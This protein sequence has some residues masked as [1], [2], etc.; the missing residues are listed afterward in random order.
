LV[1]FSNFHQ[2]LGEEADHE[3]AARAIFGLP[4]RG[5]V[6]MK[7]ERLRVDQGL[8]IQAVQDISVFGVALFLKGRHVTATKVPNQ[9]TKIVGDETALGI[10]HDKGKKGRE[11]GLNPLPEFLAE[12]VVVIAV[13]DN[14]Y[15]FG[16]VVGKCPDQILAVM[17]KFSHQ[18]VGQAG[19]TFHG[20]QLTVLEPVDF[21]DG[22][23]KR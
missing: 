12:F 20:L 1:T 21:K 5:D 18:P 16:V 19:L 17:D 14:F 15:L 3:Q 22:K 4:G 7:V 13:A 11:K 9:F 10:A 6:K 2:G 23:P 8:V